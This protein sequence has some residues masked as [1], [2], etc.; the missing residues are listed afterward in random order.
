M[1]STAYTSSPGRLTLGK[2]RFLLIDTK[3]WEWPESPSSARDSPWFRKLPVF[4]SLKV[5]AVRLL[6]GHFPEKYFVA[7]AMLFHFSNVWFWPPFRLG[8]AVSARAG[9]VPGCLQ[10][11]RR[12]R[13]LYSDLIY[14]SFPDYKTPRSFVCLFV[15]CLLVFPPCPGPL[16]STTWGKLRFPKSC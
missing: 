1:L 15:C 6:P 7:I 11:L 3:I 9:E 4:L 14:L 12:D 8:L 16:V 5:I 13:C 10:L 2:L